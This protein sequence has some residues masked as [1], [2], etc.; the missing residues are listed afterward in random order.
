MLLAVGDFSDLF[1]WSHTR[2]LKKKKIKVVHVIIASQA[3]A[4]VRNLIYRP[5]ARIELK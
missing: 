2:E 3:A 4:T 5:T 1:H